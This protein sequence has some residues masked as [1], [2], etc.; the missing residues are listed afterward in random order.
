MDLDVGWEDGAIELVGLS[1]DRLEHVLRL[2]AAQHKDDAFDRV[3]ILLIAEFAE[4]RRVADLDRA[5]VLHADGHAVIGADHHVADVFGVAHQAEA[6]HVIELPALR[7]ESAACVGVV[8]GERVDDLRNGEVVA[9]EPRGVEQ[10]LILHD[11]A[12]EAGVVGD[13]VHRAVRALDDPVLE[14]L[15]FLRASVRALDH[16]AVDEA[17]R[18]EQR[19]H[20]RRDAG[21]KAGLRHALEDNLAREVVV[22]AL[23]EGEDDVGEAVERDRPHVG[24]T[25]H[26]VEFE[27]ERQR[28]QA[29]DF[30]GGVA[31]PLRDEFN[32]RRREIGIGVNRHAPEGDDSGDGHGGRE[33]QN[34]KALA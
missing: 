26:A 30:L 19:R 16:V 6:A 2:L 7:I 11:R 9:V 3:V 1:L 29:L 18:A 21:G 31:G 13:A 28:D 32:L 23:V 10:N 24:D 22:G 12:A 14:G 33:H 27:F 17:A 5:D 4:A 25:R 8:G 20:R 34:Q 15:Q